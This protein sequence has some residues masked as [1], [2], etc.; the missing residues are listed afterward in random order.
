MYEILTK[1]ISSFCRSDLLLWSMD[2]HPK[3]NTKNMVAENGDNLGKY[4]DKGPDTLPNSSIETNNEI[5]DTELVEQEIDDDE[6]STIS[7][8]KDR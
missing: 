8:S 7:E 4:N 3:T 1:L 2:D 6:E 5:G